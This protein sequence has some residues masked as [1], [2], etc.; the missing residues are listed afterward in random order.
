MIFYSL[1]IATIFQDEKLNQLH[2]IIII[3]AWRTLAQYWRLTDS[4]WPRLFVDTTY[5]N[6][7]EN[8]ID[9]ALG[10]DFTNNTI[11]A[12]V[13]ELSNGH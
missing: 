4:I 1:A 6:I 5:T 3:M 8:F 13:A 7:Y 12:S 9:R 11:A 10:K 2:A